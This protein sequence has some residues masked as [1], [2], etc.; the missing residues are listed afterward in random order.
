MIIHIH[1]ITLITN[2]GYEMIRLVLTLAIVLNYYT[3]SNHWHAVDV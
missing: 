3:H 2:I 1:D